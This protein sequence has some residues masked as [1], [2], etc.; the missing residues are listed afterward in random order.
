[1]GFAEDQILDM[2]R[3]TPQDPALRVL[4]DFTGA[5]VQQQGR[6]TDAQLD[7]FRQGGFTDAHIAEVVAAVAQNIF[8][9]YFNHIARPD[10][11]YPAAAK[12]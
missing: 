6:V 12:I 1:M 2:R 10:L 9:S 11:D 4:A 7:A 8:T 5:V 3:G